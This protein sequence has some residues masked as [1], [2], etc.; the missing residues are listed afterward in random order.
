MLLALP[1]GVQA[2]VFSMLAGAF[3]EPSNPPVQQRVVYTAQSVPLLR[4]ATHADPN[5]S[6]GGG[7]VLVDGGALVPE[8]GFDTTVLGGGA[9]HTGGEI[10][11]YVVREGDSLSQIAEMFEVS[12]NTI[13][14]ANNIKHANLIKPGDTLVILPISGVQYVVKSGDTVAAIAQRYHGSVEDIVAYNGLASETAIAV[15]DTLVI[16]GG[17]VTPPPAPAKSSGP[18]A[19]VKSA[20]ASV[21]GYFSHPVPGAVKTQG[22]HG[23]NGVDF[24][25]PSGTPVR[26]AAAGEV[27]ISRA[28]GWNGGYGAYIVIKH[29]N[30]AQTLYA[31]NSTNYVSVGQYVSQGEEIGTVGS[32]GRSTGSHLHFE[33]RGDKNPF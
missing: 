17:E 30:G 31:H 4:A 15:G 8:R 33:V 16:P 32:S 9:T 28:S 24:G 3:A 10:S 27:I 14:W 12:A 25:A 11:V 13:L 1:L 20:V 19:A 7:D 18:L 22:I 6:K 26:A 23:Y 2:G 29:P 5:P 21:A